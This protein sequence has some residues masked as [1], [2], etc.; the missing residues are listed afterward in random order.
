MFNVK[1]AAQVPLELFGGLVTTMPAMNLP[2]G[3]SPDCQD[4]AF[5]PGAVFS[6]PGL[7]KV[8]A[9]ALGATTVTYAKS[10]TDNSGVIRNLYLDAA[11]NIWAENLNTS[12]VSMLAA[13]TPGS[14][15]KSITAFG[16]EYIAFSD[17]IHG[18]EVALQYDGTN[19]DRVTQDG[20]GA[21]PTVGNLILPD[22]AMLSGGAGPSLTIIDA[23]TTNL[24]GTTY[25]RVTVN[26]ASGG[27]GLPAGS[28]VT[29]GGNSDPNLNLTFPLAYVVNDTQIVLFAYYAT[30]ETGTGGSTTATAAYTM[31]R[32]N[33]IV[34]VN[35]ANPH[36][37]KVG[38]QAQIS[39]M[40]A[41]AFAA[42]S[43]LVINN[44]D[45]PGIATVTTSA[46]HGLASGELVILRGISSIV[47]ASPIV[48][49]VRAGG[50]VTITTTGDH[51]L[52]PGAV[53]TLSGVAD[54]T[55]NTT[56]VVTSVPD[57]TH[58]VAL[59][60]DSDSSSSGG[61][62]NLSWPIPDTPDPQVYEVLDIP[63]DS[64]F[65]VAIA[66]SDGTWTDGHVHYPWD[67]TFYVSAVTSPTQFQYKQNG[68]DLQST[69][70]GTVTPHG[71]VAPG[72][73]QLQV[74]FLTRQGYLTRPSPPA[75]WNANGNQYITVDNIPIG[76]P[77]VVARILAFTGAGGAYFFYIPVPAQV[78]GQVVS[79]ATQINDNTTTSAILDFGDNTLF[80]ALGISIPGN[81]LANMAVLDSALGFAF[82]GDRLITYGQRNV[83]QQLLNMG[84]DGGVLPSLPGVPTGWAGTGTVVPGNFGQGVS[85]P[86]LTQSFYAD[87]NGAPIAIGNTQY[88]ARC[89]SDTGATVTITSASTAFTATATITPGPGGWGEAKFSAKTPATIPSD[90]ILTLAAPGIVDDLSLVYSDVPF[91]NNEFFGSYVNNPE[92]FDDVSGV[93]GVEDTHKILSTEIIRGSMYVLTQD[94]GGRLHVVQNNGV[95][96]PAGWSVN[97][98]AANCGV[99]S[100]FA[101]TVSQADDATAGGGEEWFAWMSF[102]NPRIFGGDQPWKIGQEIQPD[103]NAINPAAWLTTW[104]LNDPSANRIYFGL[105]KGNAPSRALATAP[106]KI[107]HVDYQQMD[108][109]YEIAAG[110]P[111]HMTMTGKLDGREISRKW[112]PWNIPANGAAMIYRAVGGPLTTV[113]FVGNGMYP[114]SV[115]GGCGNV[116]ALC[117]NKLTDDCLGQFFP[118]YVTH[119]FTPPTN[120]QSLQLGGARHLLQY[121]QWNAAG[122]VGNIRVTLYIDTLSN[123]W[124]ISAT[125]PLRAD[126]TYDDEWGGGSANG[127]RIFI[128]F[129][130]LP[131]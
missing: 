127:Q 119:A 129:E 108:T 110:D 117:D 54:A 63:T 17:G 71:Q 109:A 30:F 113:F 27:L 6:R 104:A 93:F 49:A 13:V 61:N 16:R 102:A 122:Q 36:G 107:Y 29:I 70:V 79:T 106:N 41:P 15:A 45:N 22:T 112:C 81:D 116:F 67:G 25:T 98:V 62:I 38:Y 68:P 37:L 35:T 96:E 7:S 120:E 2:S 123:P 44:T 21:P 125:L 69:T 64:S 97:E 131:A 77:N 114:G 89:W 34:T 33:N 118:Y 46:P 20:P 72:E 124:P 128:K 42:I 5:R 99:M 66:W 95:T 52:I 80:A 65:T 53:V 85:V 32:G 75:R 3:V 73:H 103:W 86:N 105:P 1:G 101:S 100:P 24:V 23:T 8:L 87:A 115:P 58:F 76:P 121:L 4:M 43:T 90:L 26:L 83:V 9:T 11:G 48:A 84:F 57:S 19:L 94:P 126:P 130:G 14:Y 78:N 31:A 92:A 91:I 60:N 51:D 111:I 55:F 10:Y 39:G 47:V 28:I 40:D 12:T 74:L 82:Y 50:I 18:T 88:T 56:L 59:Q